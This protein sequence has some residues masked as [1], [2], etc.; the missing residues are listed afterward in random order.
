MRERPPRATHRDVELRHVGRPSRS[1]SP[2][3]RRRLPAALLAGIAVLFASPLTGGTVP[4]Q[5]ILGSSITA[6]PAAGAAAEPA[7]G[8]ADGSLVGAVGSPVGGTGSSVSDTGSRSRA[9]LPDPAGEESVPAARQAP[10]ITSL[11]GYRWPIRNASLTLPYGPTRF[12]SW[13]VDGEPF[14]DGLDLAT[15]CGDRITAAHGGTVLAAGRHYDE[16]MGWVG[17]LTAYTDR[18]N[19]KHLWLTLPNVVVIDDGNGYWSVY[20]HLRFVAVAPGDVVSAGDYLGT[21]GLTGR[22]TGCHLHYGLFSPYAASTFGLDPVAASHMLLPTEELARIDPLRVLP[23][24][25][26]AGI[27]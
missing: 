11:T 6:E 18:L 25:A 19:K 24:Q 14:H 15:F 26:D 13:I 4:Q 27:H 7:A 3:R 8:A 23:P 2:S 16:F 9:M 10:P 22:A 5:Q 21:E 12:G 20:A 17:D 1:R